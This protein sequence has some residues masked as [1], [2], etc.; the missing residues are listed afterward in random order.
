MDLN[1]SSQPSLNK[2]KQERIRRT[3]RLETTCDKKKSWTSMIK[4][5]A[6]IR[7]NAPGHRV[8]ACAQSRG[9]TAKPFCTTLDISEYALPK[10]A[11]KL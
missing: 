3:P 5:P 2:L 10:G 9:S 4:A 7:D 1:R 6:V 11:K 8:L